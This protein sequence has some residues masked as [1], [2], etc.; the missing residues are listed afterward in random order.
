MQVTNMADLLYE[1][2]RI[3]ELNTDNF[4]VE[5]TPTLS[6]HSDGNVWYTL[7]A[8]EDAERHGFVSGAGST[9]DEAAVKAGEGLDTACESWG[10]ER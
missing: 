8:Y 3:G 1:L 7:L 2:D 10:Y 4:A 9:P 5:I 6:R